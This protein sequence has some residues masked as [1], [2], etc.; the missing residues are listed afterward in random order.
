[1]EDKPFK[2]IDEL[3]DT[4]VSRNVIVENRDFAKRVL[5]RESYYAVINGYKDPFLDKAESEARGEDYYK[6][7]TTFE[8]FWM[9]YQTD[10][11]LRSR[12]RDILM[13][14][15][16]AMKTATVYS[17]CYYHREADSYLDPSS[18]IPIKDYRYKKSYTRSLIR[19][20]NVLQSI[21]DN[22]QKKKY[23]QHYLDRH[24]CLPLWVASKA[25]TFGNMGA[26][27]N[28]QEGKVQNAV[29]IN[30]RKALVKPKRSIGIKDVRQAYDV[31][32]EFRNLCAHKERLYCAS[33][34]KGKY[35]FRDM[36]ESL[37]VA[38][39]HNSMS[40]YI[41]QVLLIID[42][43]KRKGASIDMYNTFMEGL[44]ITEEELSSYVAS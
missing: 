9:F 14:A 11:A 13:V 43:I 8:D 18:Y 16:A 36:L 27:F 22:K 34:G 23:V 4:L 30:L 39:D 32:P 35:C 37:D 3:I 10:V 19:L 5:G 33:V 1:M 44:H 29:C 38:L 21:Y 2:T 20:L 17:F 26:F 41:N 40:E 42:A 31:L 7:G 24:G 15:E 6:D 25:L 28:L 12:T